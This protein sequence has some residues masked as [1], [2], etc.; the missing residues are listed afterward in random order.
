[1]L[2][3]FQPKNTYQFSVDRL[4]NRVKPCKDNVRL[5]YLDCNLKEGRGVVRNTSRY[6]P[7]SGKTMSFPED[8]A[9]L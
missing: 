7:L 9:T 3:I 2:R 8:S 4:V 5:I 1:M 6:A